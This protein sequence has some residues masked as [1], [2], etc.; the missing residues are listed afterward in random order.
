MDVVDVQVGCDGAVIT[1]TY[2]TIPEGTP[3]DAA[4]RKIWWATPRLHN[5]MAVE[6]NNLS[7]LTIK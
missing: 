5:K 2:G 1:V 6:N 7:E 3:R 4:Q